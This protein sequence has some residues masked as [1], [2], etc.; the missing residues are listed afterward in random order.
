M[1]R[2]DFIAGLGAAVCPLAARAQQGEQ[3]RRVGVLSFGAE[4]GPSLQLLQKTREELVKLGWI[5][6]RNL[7]LEYRFGAGD[8]NRTRDFAVDLVRLAPDVIVV[9]FGTALRA[10]QE[11]TKTIPIV[12]LRAGDLIE[13]GFVKDA[14]RPEGNTTRSAASGRSCS[15]RLPRTSTASYFCPS[16]RTRRIGV[17]SKRPRNRWGCKSLRS[18]SLMVPNCRPL[19]K[20]LLRSRTGA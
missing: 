5:E 19:S 13:G 9:G 15:R 16:I 3:V 4:S 2:R 10:V 17:Q 14:A 20:R 11:E 7:R 18:Q 6:G 8:L 1:R 12:V